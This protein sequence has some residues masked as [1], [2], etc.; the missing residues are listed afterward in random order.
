MQN[1]VEVLNASLNMKTIKY[2]IHGT[3]KTKHTDA[4]LDT[5]RSLEACVYLWLLYVFLVTFIDPLHSRNAEV[6]E[7]EGTSKCKE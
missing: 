1:E 7:G 4:A 2:N 3:N 6:K 5:Y